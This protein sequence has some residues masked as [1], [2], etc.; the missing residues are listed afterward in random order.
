MYFTP[1]L[2]N[3]KHTQLDTVLDQ[4]CKI[5]KYSCFKQNLENHEVVGLHSFSFSTYIKLL[6]L[7]VCLF[8]GFFKNV[9]TDFYE[10][11]RGS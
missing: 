5:C 10:T 3:E 2:I 11:F 7:S 8:F 6:R 1:A 4:V 9:R